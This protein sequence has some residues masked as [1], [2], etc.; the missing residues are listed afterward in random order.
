[1]GAGL[2]MLGGRDSFGA[3]GW[4]NTAVEKALPV[5]LQI[6]ALRSGHRRHGADHA[7]QRDRRGQLL[8][9]GGRQGGHQA[10]SSQDYCGMIH[11]DG[12]EAWLFTL[13]PWAPAEQMLRGSTA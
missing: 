3:G 12:Q 4:T 2:V 9:E 13:R 7:R 5:D 11:W 8:A 10:L 6:K 1:M